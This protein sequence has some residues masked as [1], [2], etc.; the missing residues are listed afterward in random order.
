MLSCDMDGES[1]GAGRHLTPLG[2][3]PSLIPSSLLSWVL[4]SMC[5]HC[6]LV[7]L[8]VG[9]LLVSCNDS[10]EPCFSGSLLCLFSGRGGPL[11]T[12]GLRFLP[13]PLLPA[14]LGLS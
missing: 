13:H 4:P 14:L 6:S 3:C 12:A 1:S 7:S 9:R 10:V 2:L 8:S 11:L 5:L